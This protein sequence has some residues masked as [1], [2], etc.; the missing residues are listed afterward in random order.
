[1]RDCSPPRSIRRSSMWT[2]LLSQKRKNQIST[3][4]STSGSRCPSGFMR[5]TSLKRSRSTKTPALCGHR[6]ALIKANRFIYNNKAKTVEI[7]VKYTQQ[8][9]DVVSQTYD[10]LSNAGAWPVNNAWPETW[11][12]WTINQQVELGTIKAQ[13]KPTYEK[14][15]D[16]SVI[17]AALSKAGGAGPATSVGLKD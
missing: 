15:I 10:I 14:F 6:A 17:E 12:S 9:S 3:F 11:S 8:D 5:P 16:L 4:S 1:L 7:A 13:E 2:R